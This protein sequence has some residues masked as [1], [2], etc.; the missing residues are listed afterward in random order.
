M[1]IRESIHRRVRFVWIFFMAFLLTAMI[2]EVTF[3]VLVMRLDS[4]I[5]VWIVVSIGLALVLWLLY[6]IKCPRCQLPVGLAGAMGTVSNCP[7]CEVSFA[8]SALAPLGTMTSAPVPPLTIRK[9][10]QRRSGKWQT[11][12]LVCL[13]VGIIGFATLYDQPLWMVMILGGL[14]GVAGILA[15]MIISALTPCPRCSTKLGRAGAFALWKKPTNKCSACGVHF[16]EPTTD[17]GR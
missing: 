10:L 11:A 1:T 15:A 2:G 13:F 8:E 9:Y 14:S 17:Q 4:K 3:S 7:N 12:L 6:R 5:A 16:D